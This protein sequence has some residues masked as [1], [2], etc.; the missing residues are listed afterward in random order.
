MGMLL[1]ALSGM[2]LRTGDA[3]FH[4]PNLSR[5]R[6]TSPPVSQMSLDFLR[7]APDKEVLQIMRGVCKYS[8]PLFGVLSE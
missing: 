7:D 2:Q 8:E 5:L 3:L 6:R 4:R 1:L